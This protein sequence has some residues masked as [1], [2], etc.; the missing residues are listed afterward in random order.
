[1]DYEHLSGALGDYQRRIAS[2]ANEQKDWSLTNLL[3]TEVLLYKTDDDKTIPPTFL[4]AIP[5]RQRILLPYNILSDGD[6]IYPYYKKAK[7]DVVAERLMDK[8]TIRS[9]YKD[10]RIGDVGY[11]TEGGGGEF[12]SLNHDISGIWIENKLPIPLA[13]HYKGDLV[14]QLAG[15]DGKTYFGGSGAI[16]Y[17]KG[18]TS[19]GVDYAGKVTVSYSLPGTETN[20]IVYTFTISDVNCKRIVIGIVNAG[21]QQPGPGFDVRYCVP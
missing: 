15:Y 13:L 10:I 6:V 4:V 9:Y 19:N 5:P 12:Q 17:F 11:L 1:M 2:I 20:P 16:A 7:K 8:Y 18:D 14:M 3:P 21:Y